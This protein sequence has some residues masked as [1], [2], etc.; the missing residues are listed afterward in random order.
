[1]VLSPASSYCTHVG[2]FGQ[3]NGNLQKANSH[4]IG[5]RLWNLLHLY[6]T[7]RADRRCW[8]LNR[9]FAGAT[10][11]CICPVDMFACGLTVVLWVATFLHPGACEATN[12]TAAAGTRAVLPCRRTS[13]PSDWKI[14]EAKWF[15]SGSHGA[16]LVLNS[17]RG[18]TSEDGRSALRGQLDEGDVSLHV[19]RLRL[20]DAGHYRCQAKMSK[21]WW[22]RQRRV[23]VCNVMLAVTPDEGEA[24]DP[25]ATSQENPATT[26]PR[27]GGVDVAVGLAVECAGGATALGPKERRVTD[28]TAEFTIRLA[29]SGDGG[30][31][32]SWCA[33]VLLVPA[34]MFVGSTVALVVWRCRVN[35]RNMAK[36]RAN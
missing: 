30:Q 29:A 8:D 12:V 3:G 4:S 21:W 7:N 22:T 34:V 19:E 13:W 26:T 16:Q 31:P 35:R 18:L 32:G 28:A 14:E 15:H 9:Y 24:L 27:G 10:S 6:V 25:D 23:F 20:R 2:G 11:G 33:L 5:T 1:M 17:V 36:A